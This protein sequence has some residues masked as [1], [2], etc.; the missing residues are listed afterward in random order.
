MGFSGLNEVAIA[1]PPIALN[2]HLQI[3]YFLRL[4]ETIFDLRFW[5][6]IDLW[7]PKLVDLVMAQVD[8]TMQ[9]LYGSNL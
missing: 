8:R 9:I 7:N 6:A 2:K 1:Y 4:T 3:F 5:I